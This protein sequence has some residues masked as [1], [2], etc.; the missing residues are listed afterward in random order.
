LARYD[1]AAGDLARGA[2]GRGLP[3]ADDEPGELLGK[4][5]MAGSM[6]YDGYTDRGATERKIVRD[7]FEPGDA[8]FRSGDLLRR[9]AEGYY[10]FVDRIGDTFRWKGENVATT[11]VADVLNGAPG[12]TETTVYGVP[13]PG[14]DGRAG[15]A[16]VV[17]ATDTAFDG[18]AFYAHAARHLPRYAMPAFVRLS[19]Q[20][21]VTG[22]LKQ[23][24]QALAAEGWDPA[25]VAEPLFVRDDAGERYVP[26]TPARH[27]EITSGRY[28]L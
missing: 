13:I 17:L 21:D 6:D 8:W 11:E 3:C 2:D 20:I 25:T 7:V 28:R 1:V 12:I 16:A 15:M 14:D 23:R 9:D 5:G 18:Q 19:G 26:L 4:V 27:G 24:K 22:T 10:Y